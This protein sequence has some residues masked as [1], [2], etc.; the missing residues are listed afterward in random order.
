MVVTTKDTTFVLG[1]TT[2]ETWVMD[3][4]KRVFVDSNEWA[5]SIISVRH[6]EVIEYDLQTDSWLFVRGLNEDARTGEVANLSIGEGDR[7]GNLAL[8]VKKAAWREEIVVVGN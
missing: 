6:A 2:S 4:K 8:D 1:E 5:V 3:L 7:G